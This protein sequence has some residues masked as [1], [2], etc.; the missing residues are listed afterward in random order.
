M[1]KA[2]TWLLVIGWISAAL[3]GLVG[4]FIGA[5]LATAKAPAEAAKRPS[6]TT[7]TLGGRVSRW[8]SSVCWSSRSGR[9]YAREDR[10]V[11]AGSLASTDPGS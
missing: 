2:S 3:G 10:A 7:T 4:I 8:P 5:Y 9:G 1:K 6:S 11:E